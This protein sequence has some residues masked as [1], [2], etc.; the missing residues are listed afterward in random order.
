M[1]ME[2]CV[3]CAWIAWRMYCVIN[4]TQQIQRE[5][6]THLVQRHGAADLLRQCQ[7]SQ[8]RPSC[9]GWEKYG[10]RCYPQVTLRDFCDKYRQHI[11][12]WCFQLLTAHHPLFFKLPPLLSFH[13]VK[14]PFS[15]SIVLRLAASP[16]VILHPSVLSPSPLSHVPY[17]SFYYYFSNSIARESLH[18]IFC[19]TDYKNWD[20]AHGNAVTP[21]RVEQSGCKMASC[22]LDGG[23]GVFHEG[24]HSP[25]LSLP[26]RLSWVSL[27]QLHGIG[28][29]LPLDVRQTWRLIRLAVM[30]S[31][32]LFP[33]FLPA[34]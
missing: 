33:V 27:R 10:R 18:V 11:V 24:Y 26:N 3:P 32:Y 34:F 1:P 13:Y 9:R 6:H 16:K 4:C 15:L 2:N 7:L 17:I 21:W 12:T 28:I 31:C 23:W 20:L 29:A 25:S 30:K 19:V 8:N 14:I 5:R 22:G